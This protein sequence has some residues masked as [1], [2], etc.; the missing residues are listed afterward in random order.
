MA[1]GQRNILLCWSHYTPAT[2]LDPRLLCAVLNAA[3]GSLV[4]RPSPLKVAPGESAEV[5]PGEGLGAAVGTE[6]GFALAWTTKEGR[7]DEH[8]D[9]VAHLTVLTDAG[10]PMTTRKLGGEGV[11]ALSVERVGTELAVAWDAT[12]G[13]EVTWLGLDGQEHRAPYSLD[14]GTKSH[15]PRLAQHH[16]ML[17]VGWGDE[18]SGSGFIAV[19]DPSGKVSPR[20]EVDSRPALVPTDD[21]FAAA[22]GLYDGASSA[23]ETLICRSRASDG[24]PDRII[25][26]KQ[27]R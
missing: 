11:M 18:E 2:I 13:I 12:R 3:D 21:G 17:A 5:Q 25:V 4:R 14:S 24:P 19:T 20:F 8:D 1:W 15:H 10:E 27:E 26:P 7:A 6:Q 9:R 23:V 22:Y 16:G